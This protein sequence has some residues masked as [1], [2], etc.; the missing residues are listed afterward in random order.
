[1]KSKKKKKITI[2]GNES[3]VIQIKVMEQGE[4]INPSLFSTHDCFQDSFSDVLYYYYQKDQKDEYWLHCSTIN[5]VFNEHNKYI[6][7]LDLNFKKK[8]RQTININKYET[9]N[10]SGVMDANN[11]NSSKLIF[12]SPN[13]ENKYDISSSVSLGLIWDLK[14]SIKKIETWEGKVAYD[15][16]FK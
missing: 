12:S 1:M 7:M 2:S 15:C 14:M 4:K 16:K 5:D 3:T 8:K 10:S 13:R 11:L 6:N 9:S